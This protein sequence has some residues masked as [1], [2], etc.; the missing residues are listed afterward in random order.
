MVVVLHSGLGNAQRI[1]ARQSED[2]LNMDEIAEQR[3]FIVAYLNGTPVTRF[4][5]V[6]KLGRNAGGGCCGQPAQNNVDDV[7]Y[8]R[9]P[10]EYLGGQFGIDRNKIYG[11]GHSNGAMMNQ[12]LMCETGIYAAI[13]AI[14]GPLNLDTPNCA[15]ASGK[16]ILAIHGAQDENVPL[17]G[18]RGTKRISRA[19][20]NSEERSRV[21]FTSAGA[22]YTL[23]VVE[24]ADHTLDNIED[25]IE[26]AEG[27]SIP[28][29]AALFFGLV[30]PSRLPN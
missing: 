16:R 15:A 30:K 23:Q 18:G 13:V 28:E 3:G 14:S 5:G 4:F 17:A 24:G 7:H 1:E 9:S 6:D 26:K 12:R 25:A 2:G 10:I 20:C 8:I 22:A 29:K 27:L 21:V 11:M 19:V